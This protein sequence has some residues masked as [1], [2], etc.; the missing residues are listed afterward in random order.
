VA[1]TG[2]KFRQVTI[3]VEATTSGQSIEADEVRYPASVP[4]QVTVRSS[5]FADTALA[6]I[7]VDELGPSLIDLKVIDNTIVLAPPRQES[8]A[9]MSRVHA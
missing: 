8:S 1:V 7:L 9:P 4:S 5:R 2:S 6:A 3:G